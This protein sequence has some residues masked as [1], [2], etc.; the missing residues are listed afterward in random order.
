M[1]TGLR[2]EE[3]EDEEVRVFSDR[4]PV[5][6]VRSSRHRDREDG[7]EIWDEQGTG[8]ERRGV[9]VEKEKRPKREL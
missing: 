1:N 4:A 5:C 3:D 7:E 9:G 2:S 8:R 6:F